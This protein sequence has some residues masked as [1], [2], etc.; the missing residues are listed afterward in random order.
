MDQVFQ[1]IDQCDSAAGEAVLYNMLHCTDN[2]QAQ[3]KEL[4]KYYEE[5]AEPRKKAEAILISL[6]KREGLYYLPDT[7]IHFRQ[8]TWLCVLLSPASDPPSGKCCGRT[9]EC[10]DPAAGRR[11]GNCQYCG[12]YYDADEI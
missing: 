11:D 6:G 7:W 8:V 12:L 2:G 9:V 1:R 5:Q 3:W 10:S 4:L